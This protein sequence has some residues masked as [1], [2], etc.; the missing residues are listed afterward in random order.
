M[1]PIGLELEWLSARL[2]VVV[3]IDVIIRQWLLPP[4]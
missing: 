4:R 2:I 3:V 1:H